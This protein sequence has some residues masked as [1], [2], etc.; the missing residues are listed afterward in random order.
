MS[1][2]DDLNF[3]LSQSEK[4]NTG[5]RSKSVMNSELNFQKYDQRSANISKLLG[6]GEKRFVDMPEKSA[7]SRY[8][9]YD[10]IFKHERNSALSPS[11]DE[12]NKYKNIIDGID[13]K[14]KYL[15]EGPLT[16]SSRVKNHFH[17]RSFSQA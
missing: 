4:K 9:K 15:K 3:K 2:L 16:Q 11:F 12:M 10:K 5:G 7:K 6:D 13:F 17:N 8:Q 14:Q 1:F